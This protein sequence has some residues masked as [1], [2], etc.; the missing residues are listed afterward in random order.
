MTELEPAPVPASE[1]ATTAVANYVQAVVS[2]DT[3]TTTE[4]GVTEADV[5]AMIDAALAETQETDSGVTESDVQAA[6]DAALD[7]VAWQL[8]ANRMGTQS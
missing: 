3:T 5:Q 6:I 8:Q 7:D 4:S 1:R 2:A